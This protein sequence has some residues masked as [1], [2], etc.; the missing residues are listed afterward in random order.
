MGT[1][2]ILTPLYMYTSTLLCHDLTTRRNHKSSQ[3]Y[4]KLHAQAAVCSKIPQADWCAGFA[5]YSRCGQWVILVSLRVRER[6]SVQ[7]TTRSYSHNING[8]PILTNTERVKLQNDSTA[9]CF[10]IQP[11][12][13]FK[14]IVYWICKAI[15]N[16]ADQVI[17]FHF[18]CL[19]NESIKKTD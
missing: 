7:E 9:L 16:T 1:L 14:I 8:S 10:L 15:P 5:H 13:P 18:Q 2:D 4:E 6:G 11:A 19:L 12:A 3:L 17:H